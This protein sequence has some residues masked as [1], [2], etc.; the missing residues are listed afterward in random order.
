[1]RDNIDPLRQYSDKNVIKILNDFALFKGMDNKDKLNLDIKEG[2][3]NLS[4]GQKQLICFAR[5]LIKGNKIIILDEA[6]SSLDIETE[7]IIEVNIQKYLKNVTMLVITHHI[8]NVKNYKKIVVVDQGRIVESGD[9]DSL[10]KNKSSHFYS[11]YEESK[12]Q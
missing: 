9:Y 6:T 7:K 8:H 4:N 5:A 12:K 1:M 2:G 10:L 11:L 3:K